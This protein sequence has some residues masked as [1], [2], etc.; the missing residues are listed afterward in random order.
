MI[1]I[2]T[3]QYNF[4]NGNVVLHEIPTSD[5][6]SKTARVSRTATLDGGVYINHFGSSD[7]DRT[8]KI[9][10]RL[11]QEQNSIITNMYYNQP[12]ILIS[13]FDGFYTGTID[14]INNKKGITALNIF[15]KERLA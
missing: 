5:L 11:T 9:D 14:S 3:M 2:S 13:M 10:V 7:G 6:S 8:L 15:I 1:S 12:F 4:N